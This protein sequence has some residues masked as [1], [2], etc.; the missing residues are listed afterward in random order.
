MGASV[1]PD[2]EAVVVARRITSGVGIVDREE[3]VR[4]SLAADASIA[5]I[6]TSKSSGETM[7]PAQPRVSPDGRWVAFQ[8]RNE[9]QIHIRSMDG[10]AGVQV[11]DAGG[12]LPVWDRN[13]SRLF[14]QSSA[15]FMAAQLQ[16]SPTLAV[17]RHDRIPA[18]SPAGSIH[19]L[20]N[21]GKTFLIVSPVDPAVRVLVTVNWAADVRRQLGIGK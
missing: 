18:F 8:D 3:I 14:Y 7:R 15:G 11:S 6:L 16:T 2:S 21:D 4:I 1:V 10:K 12:E 5:P 9:R 13:S 20:S 17:L 19:D